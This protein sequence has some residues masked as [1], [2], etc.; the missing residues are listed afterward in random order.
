MSC[1]FISCEFRLTGWSKKYEKISQNQFGLQKGKYVIDCVF[2][3]HTVMSKVLSKSQK[4]YCIFI[5]YEKCFDKIERSLL[6]QKLLAEHISCKLVKAIK[7]MYT[8]VKSCV[9]YRSSYSKFFDSSIGLKQ[10]D[11][12]SPLLFMFFL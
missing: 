11:P 10:G 7:S 8:V 2:V 1:V 3:L 6:W 12:S 9:K 4:L 5:D